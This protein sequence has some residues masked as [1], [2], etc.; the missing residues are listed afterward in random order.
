MVDPAFN[1]ENL[2]CCFHELD[3]R[4]A[5]GADRIS[6]EDYAVN[7]EKNIEA[8]LKR[9]KNQTYYPAPVKGVK[10]PKGNEELFKAEIQVFALHLVL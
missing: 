2:I 9:M 3:G 6:K 7:L 1:K 8:L 10:I 5:I 4:K